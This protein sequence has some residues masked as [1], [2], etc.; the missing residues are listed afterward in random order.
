MDNPKENRTF[1]HFPAES[2]CPICGDGEDG[3]CVLV[4]IQGTQS[5][6][7]IEAVPVHLS[8]LAN[9]KRYLYNRNVNVIYVVCSDVKRGD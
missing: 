8:C 4:G 3:A 1:D 5:D 9:P 7:N 2:Q 6:G